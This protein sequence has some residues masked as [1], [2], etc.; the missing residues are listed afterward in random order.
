ML[1][2]HIQ[3]AGISL[4][5]MQAEVEEMLAG[6]TDE[7]RAKKAESITLYADKCRELYKIMSDM[8]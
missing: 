2:K 4:H 8:M 3:K 5:F 6:L 1:H 7:Q